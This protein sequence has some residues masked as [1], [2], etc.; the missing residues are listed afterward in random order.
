MS[1]EK[2]KDTVR[3]RQEKADAKQ[4]E[5][6]ENLDNI[7]LKDVKESKKEAINWERSNKRECYNFN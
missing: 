5:I 7:S 1:T 4:K 6:V 3:I 2:N